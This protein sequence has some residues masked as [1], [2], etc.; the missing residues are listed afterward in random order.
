LAFICSV[1]GEGLR[2]EHITTAEKITI[3]RKEAREILD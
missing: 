1:F 2:A 3:V